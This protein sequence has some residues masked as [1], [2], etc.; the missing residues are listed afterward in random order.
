MGLCVVNERSLT[1]GRSDA[2]RMAFRGRLGA[3]NHTEL[4]LLPPWKSLDVNQHL[5]FNL[6]QIIDSG[7]R[8]AI[9][10]EQFR[11][12]LLRAWPEMD[13][14]VADAAFDSADVDRD[15]VSSSGS[16]WAAVP[17]QPSLAP[18]LPSPRRAT[19]CC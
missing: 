11:R 16:A 8:G 15:G 7:G 5:P 14:G 12:I 10:R 17:S 13:P 4:R 6:P 9:S 1:G 18:P 19:D 2:L 3:V